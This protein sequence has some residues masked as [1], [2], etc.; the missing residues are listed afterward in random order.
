ME[1]L[2]FRSAIAARDDHEVVLAFFDGANTCVAILKG[3]EE[4][5]RALL[6]A[7]SST[8]NTERS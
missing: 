8:L 5:A 4:A 6:E 7:L 3:S 2:T 1:V